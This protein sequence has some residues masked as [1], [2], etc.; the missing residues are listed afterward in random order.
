MHLF[1]ILL[2]PTLVSGMIGYDCTAP[3]E[4]VRYS[5]KISTG[6]ENLKKGTKSIRPWTGSVLQFPTQFSRKHQSCHLLER[7]ARA[8]CTWSR[9]LIYIQGV[10]TELDLVPVPV[11]IEDCKRA[12]FSGRFT[13]KNITIQVQPG[14]S[15]PIMIGDWVDAKGRCI[16]AL[17]EFTITRGRFEMFSRQII[18]LRTMEGIDRKYL[19]GYKELTYSPLQNMY[20]SLDLVLVIPAVPRIVECAWEVVYNGSGQLAQTTSGDSY[21]MVELLGA[22]LLLS[23]DSVICGLQV[24][25]TQDQNVFITNTTHVAVAP[26][27][28]VLDERMTSLT[29]V[30]SL[31]VDLMTQSQLMTDKLDILTNQCQL[32]DTIR[33]ELI[34]T[35]LLDPGQAALDLTGQPGWELIPAGAALVLKKCKEVNVVVDPGDSCHADIPIR[36][37]GTNSTG[38]MGP[39]SHTI[40]RSSYRIKCTDPSLPVFETRGHLFKLAP[41]IIEVS[42]LIPLPGRLSLKIAPLRVIQ[43][44][45]VHSIRH[46]L[47]RTRSTEPPPGMAPTHT[48][49]PSPKIKS[50]AGP[51][52]ER[53]ESGSR[54][55]RDLDQR[56]GWY[57]L[58]VGAAAVLLLGLG[59]FV[60]VI[61]WEC[62]LLGS[63]CWSHSGWRLACASEDD[64]ES[65]DNTHLTPLDLSNHSRPPPTLSATTRC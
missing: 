7:Q 17:E 40:K 30:Q 6:C 24:T 55:G 51:V 52:P 65:P 39:K 28:V 42:G 49:L 61:L 27:V 63:L 54:R 58:P 43:A 26:P 53:R 62:E 38:F 18:E 4:T 23:G 1:L 11:S 25:R 3:V 45:Q 13:I 22:G 2:I 31:G 35:A 5:D 21:I 44:R 14:G 50:I 60:L 34:H 36:L 56:D 64:V 47:S 9:N 8:Y 20:L 15:T 29:S 48:P 46:R 10:G 59:L 41:G 37:V 32:E 19:P 12:W 16:G 33:H 57:T